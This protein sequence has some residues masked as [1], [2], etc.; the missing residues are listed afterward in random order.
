[1]LARGCLGA[2]LL[3]SPA[4]PRAGGIRCVRDE[5]PAAYAPD[6]DRGTFILGTP[7][8]GDM[9]EVIDVLMDGFYKDVLTLAADEFSEEEMEAEARRH[10]AMEHLS[11]C[12]R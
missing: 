11:R 3:A 12:R 2:L 8:P 5:L 4:P 6:V 10:S 1:M 7:E 9:P